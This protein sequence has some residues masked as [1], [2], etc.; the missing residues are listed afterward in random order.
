M[1]S[2]KDCQSAYGK[3]YVHSPSFLNLSTAGCQGI[4]LIL[5]KKS[6]GSRFCGLLYGQSMRISIT[7]FFPTN[8]DPKDSLKIPCCVLFQV[9]SKVW[10]KE[11]SPQK[12]KNVWIMLARG[13]SHRF[14]PSNK[15]I[16]IVGER[17]FHKCRVNDWWVTTC[18]FLKLIHEFN[19]EEFPLSP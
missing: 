17:D 8:M 3:N 18:E 2:F 10:S 4:L 16:V 11:Y 14:M 5:G 9:C 7:D 15:Q 1:C 19:D 13:G 12:R 6:W